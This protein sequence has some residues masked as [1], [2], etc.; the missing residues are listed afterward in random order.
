M[1]KSFLMI[2]A[3]MLIATPLPAM[4]PASSL[5]DAQ[6]AHIAYTAGELDVETARLALE[7]S[8][9]ADVRAF[10][11]T[12]VRDHQA[13]NQ[14]ALALLQRLQVTP[15]AH[16]T[17]AALTSQAAA[18]RARLA[19]LEGSAFDRAYV[20]NEAAYHRTVNGA[21]SGTLIPGAHNAELKSLLE[22]G[23]ALFGAHQAHAEQLELRL[24]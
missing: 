12:M 17:S 6:I 2:G 7:K 14:A 19:A 21:L 8:R 22:S 11:E 13:V 5:S 4:A 20:A 24:R 16:A 10:A 1:S 9:N 15:E 18:D 23:L 3:A